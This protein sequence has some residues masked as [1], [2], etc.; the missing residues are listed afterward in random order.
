MKKICFIFVTILLFSIGCL[1]SCDKKGNSSHEE[2]LFTEYSL[3]N[4]SC[5]WVN[6]NYDNS[7]IVINSSEKL[8]NYIECTGENNYQDVDFSKHTL[9]LA[10]G[11]EK[12][13]VSPNSKSFKKLSA[14]NYVMNVNLCPEVASVFTY[15]HVPIIIDKIA[16]NSVVELIVTKNP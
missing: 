6:L 3:I 14:Q 11:V 1:I 16:D 2:V 12:H 7:V 4:T 8:R 9:L 13:L 5:Q 10:Q 15:W